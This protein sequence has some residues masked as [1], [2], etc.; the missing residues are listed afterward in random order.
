[1]LLDSCISLDT[2][3]LSIDDAFGSLCDTMIYVTVQCVIYVMWI[4]FPAFASTFHHRLPW[5]FI[6]WLETPTACGSQIFKVIRQISRSHRPKK[7]QVKR[8]KSRVFG[9]ILEKAWGKGLKYHMLLYPDHLIRFCHGLLILLILVAFWLNETF[10]MC[11][12]RIWWRTHDSNG[13]KF[14][15]LI[16]SDYL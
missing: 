15:M 7:T 1:M 8:V 10:Q 3:I 13:L 14:G 5:Y 11:G 2:S 9:H 4:K 16:Y 12:F 6:R